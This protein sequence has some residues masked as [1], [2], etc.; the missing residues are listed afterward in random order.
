M[1]VCALA[2][3]LFSVTVSPSPAAPAAVA[4][5]QTSTTDESQP[6]VAET[7]LVTATRSERAVS[8]L[9]VSATVISEEQIRATPARS[10]DDLL[11]DIP[12]VHLSLISGSGSTPNNQRISMHGL[13]G[14]RA[15]VLL[16]GIP[17]HDPYSGIVQW[18]KVPIESVRQVEVV[19]GGNASLF[20]NFAL[21][22]TINLITR[23]VDQSGA[24]ADL[25]IGTGSTQRAAFTIDHVFSPKVAV[26]VSHN[27]NDSDGF[28]RVPEAGP[29]DIAAWIDSAI[30]AA[31]TDLHFSDR[32][33]AFV[34]ASVSQIDISQGTPA[35]YSKRDIVATSGGLHRGFGSSALLS[36]N[37]FYQRQ[38]E[39]LVNSTILGQRVS[40]FISQDGT[41]PSTTAGAS[42]E[43]SLQRRG[44]LAFLSFGA[45]IR[46]VEAS[47]DRVSF[48]R[49][50]AVTQ[51]NRVGGRQRFAGFYAQASWQP[52]DRV[53]VLGSARIDSFHNEN[54][55]DV[56]VGGAIT[57]YPDTSST[58]LDPRLSIR[59]GIGARSAVRGSIYR[60]FNAPTLRDLYRNNQTGNSIV[61][62]N[63]F[64]QP[65]TLVGGEIGWEWARDNAHV[66]INLY[67]S[68]VTGLQSRAPVPGQPPNVFRNLNL[69]KSRSQGVEVIGDL[70]ISRRW[71]IHTGYTFADSTIIEDPS[72]D[73]LGKMVPEVPRHIGSMS[74]RFRG[75]RGT[76]ADLR[77]RVVSRS[78]GEAANLALSPAHRVVDFSVSQAL[79]PWVDVYA[80]V[81]NAFDESYYLAL[82]PTSFR[83]GLP[84]TITGGVRLRGFRR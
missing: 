39:R 60:A 15:L 36:A 50:G 82:A 2:F 48:N 52:T 11:R 4:S 22:G 57:A 14:S 77:G 84:R 27:H 74:V 40:E 73:L 23:P 18:Q 55:S 28:V 1:S 34:N 31:R 3:L 25:S 76:S 81:E 13:G 69:G 72:P 49:S 58:Q 32:T 30:T 83:S 29:I 35:T 46:E 8:E 21:G 6:A 5:E 9:P 66:E 78:Y 65:E 62:G 17:L 54:G 38:S 71:S 68:T 56:I 45:D 7:I 70:R 42:L 33:S 19:R 67:R 53:E 75:D 47:E 12:G 59:Y 24:Q 61:L 63:P 10:I 16:D 80:M 26:R 51:R 37:A 43:W 20:G 44:A 64:L 41:I 79:R